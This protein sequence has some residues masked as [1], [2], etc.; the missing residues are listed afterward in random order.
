[1]LNIGRCN[2]EY[3]FFRYKMHPLKTKRVVVM[4]VM[5]VMVVVVV[6]TL[7]MGVVLGMAAMAVAVVV[8]GPRRSRWTEVGGDS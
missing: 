1:M 4:V 6:V 7:A 2:R 3:R 8:V 5:M